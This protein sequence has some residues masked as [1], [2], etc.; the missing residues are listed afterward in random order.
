M[1]GAVFVLMVN[2][3]RPM[4]S[5]NR[6]EIF[7]LLGSAVVS[8][9]VATFAQSRSVPLVGWLSPSTESSDADSTKSFSQGLH[10]QGYDEAGMS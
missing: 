1:L 4:Q 2:P 10:E 9:P 3:R 8:Q 5:M 7:V 6:R